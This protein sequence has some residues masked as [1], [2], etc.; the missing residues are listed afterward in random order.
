MAERPLTRKKGLGSYYTDPVVVDFLVDWGMSVAPGSVMDPSCGDGRFL[1]A[2]VRRGAGRVIGCDLDEEALESSADVVADLDVQS[3][4]L[5]SDFFLLDPDRIGPVDLVVGNP[6]FIRFQQFS[7]E[8]RTRA[9]G[10]ALRVGARL[11]NL[12]ASWAPFLLHGLQFLRQGGR[13]Q[14][15]CRRSW[16]RPVT[17]SQRCGHFVQTSRA[18]G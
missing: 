16:P 1:Q 3:T 9:L 2:A 12:S 10:S 17:A 4:L 18:Y 15:W 8:S 14:W 6:P 13:W 5:D 7:G 11:T